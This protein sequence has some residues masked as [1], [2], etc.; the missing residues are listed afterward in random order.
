MWMKV[1]TNR[2]F[3]ETEATAN[4]AGNQEVLMA[5][6]TVHAGRRKRSGIG[7]MATSRTGWRSSRA[8]SSIVCFDAVIE[9]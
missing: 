8:G 6:R 1:E 5:T 4:Q 2:L 7:G 3:R 9:R